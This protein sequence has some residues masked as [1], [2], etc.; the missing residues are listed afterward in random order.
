M[1]IDTLFIYGII[2]CVLFIFIFAIYIKLYEWYF[3]IKRQ[4]EMIEKLIGKKDNN[5]TI[6]PALLQSLSEVDGNFFV[7][8][9]N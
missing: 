4:N 2:S 5:G 9:K 6:Y 1:A 3:K 7:D 8:L